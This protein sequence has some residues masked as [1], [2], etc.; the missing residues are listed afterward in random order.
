VGDFREIVDALAG[1]ANHHGRGFPLAAPGADPHSIA[2]AVSTA[3]FQSGGRSFLAR[4][5][6]RMLTAGRVLA[7]DCRGSAPPII[8][9]DNRPDRQLW[10]LLV[11]SECST[12]DE[13]I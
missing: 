8:P 6:T 7:Q 2:A 10:S 1:N 11:I 4:S 9:H 3:H 13:R 12:I 5:R